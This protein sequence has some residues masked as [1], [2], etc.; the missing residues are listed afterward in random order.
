M[1]HNNIKTSWRCGNCAETVEGDFE[2]CW[3]CGTS[4]TGQPD[5]D[6]IPD[7]RTITDD[8]TNDA[9]K[10]YFRESTFWAGAVCILSIIITLVLAANTPYTREMMALCLILCLAGIIGLTF[11]VI[12]PTFESKN[13]HIPGRQE[14]LRRDLY[15]NWALCPHCFTANLPIVHMCHCCATPLTT[16]AEIDPIGRIHAFGD[17]CRKACNRPCKFIIFL[18]TWILFGPNLPLY[19]LSLVDVL[20]ILLDTNPV[21]DTAGPLYPIASI[22]ES[23]FTFSTIIGIFTSTFLVVIYSIILYKITKNYFR[24]RKQ[25]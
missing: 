5:L 22:Y 14:K 8:S 25:I 11:A 19:M 17:T 6:F 7:N 21:T 16:H 15:V 20:K 10:K 12:I 23:E 3:N 24:L 13:E 9:E 4:N 1:N 2:V 18:G